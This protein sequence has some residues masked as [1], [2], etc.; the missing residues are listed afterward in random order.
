MNTKNNRQT[1]HAG[2]LMNPETDHFHVEMVCF[3]CM[4][5]LKPV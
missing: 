2:F 3:F 5:P 1:C 4:Q